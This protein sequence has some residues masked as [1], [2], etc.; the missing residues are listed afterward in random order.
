MKVVSNDGLTKLI[1]LCK[2]NFISSTDTVSASTVTLATVATSGDFTDLL[3][4]PT[5]SN[6]TV[7][8][9]QDGVTKGTFTLNQTTAS[10]INLDAGGG[11]T[12]II[13]RFS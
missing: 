3:N 12:V 10:T 7:T 8:V 9:K 11:S 5:I 13:R 2:N 1:Q 6:A 4:Q